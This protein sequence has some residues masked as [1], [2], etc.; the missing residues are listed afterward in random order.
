MGGSTRGHGNSTMSKV[1]QVE[2]GFANI[3]F[4]WSF[5][6]FLHHFQKQYSVVTKSDE[7]RGK[8][9]VFIKMGRNHIVV[10]EYSCY[11]RIIKFVMSLLQY[12]QTLR[13]GVMT[14]MSCH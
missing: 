3:L 2:W 13:V 4:Q 1:C 11:Q 7:K 9:K 6:D 10:M 12:R 14:F 5:L 8:T